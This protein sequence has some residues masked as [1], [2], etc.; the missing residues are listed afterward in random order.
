MVTRVRD[1]V[2]SAAVGG[3]G[4]GGWACG[5]RRGVTSRGGGTLAYA[6]T[7]ARAYAGRAVAIA[8]SIAILILIERNRTAISGGF[9]QEAVTARS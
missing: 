4:R 7:C 2:A 3:G 9:L 6:Y 1:I 5:V 8:I